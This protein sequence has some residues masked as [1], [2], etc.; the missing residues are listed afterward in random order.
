MAEQSDVKAF[1]SWSGDLA[2]EIAVALRDWLPLL[3]DRVRPWASDTDVAAGQRGLAQIES[4]LTDTRFGV[5]VVTAENQHAP[6][7]NFE[8][9]ALSKTVV[10]DVE[11]RVVP[12]LVDLS[13]PTQ[14]TGPLAQF[15][16]KTAQKAGML[17]VVRSLAAVAGIEEGVAGQR[18]EVYWPQLEAKIEAAK[19][20]ASKHPTT[21]RTKRRD[22]AD[23]L[24][25]ILLHVRALRSDRDPEYVLG[26]PNR[27]RREKRAVDR[28]ALHQMLDR[29]A[30]EHGL[31]VTR[32]PDPPA[33]GQTRPEVVLE[34]LEAY[35]RESA[36]A[37]ERSLNRV[38]AREGQAFKVSVVPF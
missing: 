9:G 3:F 32:Y 4:E 36:E 31:K 6:W 18:F 2:R 16:A 38:A 7:L 37:F 10:G 33:P 25:E 20:K 1:I 27:R 23:V 5:V 26:D 19:E 12:L 14:L 13:G 24:D 30:A 28:H 15:Q 17:S 29:L 22:E 34:S 8:A 21:R 11:Q 35:S